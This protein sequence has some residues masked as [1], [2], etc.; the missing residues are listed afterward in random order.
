MVRLGVVVGRAA[1]GLCDA[2]GETVRRKA[3]IAAFLAGFLFAAQL[4]ATLEPIVPDQRIH[5]HPLI[6]IISLLVVVLILLVVEL[7][8]SQKPAERW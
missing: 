3:N 1:S 8:D 7:R 5:D 6:V 4:L 2:A